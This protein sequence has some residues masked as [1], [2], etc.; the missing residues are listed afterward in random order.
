MFVTCNGE[1][2]ADR[3]VIGPVVVSPPGFPSYYYPYK[4]VKGYLSPLVSVRFERPVQRRVIN[5]ECIAWAGNIVYKGGERD[6]TGSVHFE[7]LIDPEA[8]DPTKRS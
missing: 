8:T 5:V 6:R 7:I 2:P 4:N 1:H 3:E